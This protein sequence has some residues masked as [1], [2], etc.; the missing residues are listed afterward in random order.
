[1]IQPTPPLHDPPHPCMTHPNPVVFM[2]HP[3]HPTPP[4]GFHDPPH[5]LTFL[6]PYFVVPHPMYYSNDKIVK[7]RIFSEPLLLPT[8]GRLAPL[9]AMHLFHEVQMKVT[10][11]LY[12]QLFVCIF[13]LP[14]CLIWLFCSI[15]GQNFYCEKPL[16]LKYLDKSLLENQH[17]A[18][19]FP[20]IIPLGAIQRWKYS[21]ACV[22]CCHRSTH[23]DF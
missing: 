19:S 4:C 8:F 10:C 6:D 13:L 20:C 5:P 17:S 14:G 23:H 2:N 1:M 12:I 18:F 7:E 3:L 9:A 16:R 21:S 11:I 15:P 22:Q